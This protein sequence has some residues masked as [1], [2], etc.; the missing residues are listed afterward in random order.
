MINKRFIIFIFILFITY[1]ISFINFIS[2]LNKDNIT[3]VQSKNIV[4][5]NIDAEAPFFKG[6][7]YGIIG[8]AFVVIPKLI[9]AI[10]NHK[11]HKLK[12]FYY[13]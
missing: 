10:K 11:N 9:E 8:D 6:A 5:I 12:L 13:F 1:I 3:H 2:N 4:V 7:N